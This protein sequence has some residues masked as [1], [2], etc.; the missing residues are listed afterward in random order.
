MIYT[1]KLNDNDMATLLDIVKYDFKCA[2]NDGYESDVDN[3]QQ[4][5]DLLKSI[6]LAFNNED[7]Q[8]KIKT[9]IAKYESD[10]RNA[11]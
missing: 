5:I 3:M 6:A 1:I 7:A 9:V 11:Q 8:L 2:Y 10:L 4:D